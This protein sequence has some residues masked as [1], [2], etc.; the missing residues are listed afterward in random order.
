MFGML[1]PAAFNSPTGLTAC[2]GSTLV[3]TI[4]KYNLCFVYMVK[5]FSVDINTGVM[6]SSVVTYGTDRGFNCTNL[7]VTPLVYNAVV[8]LVG[9]VI[10]V[11]LRVSSLV[12]AYTLSLVCRTFDMCTAGKG[13]MVLSTSCETFN[14]CPN[15]LVLTLVTCLLYTFVLGC[16]GVNACACTVK[17]GRIMTGGVNMGIPGC[18]VMTFALTKFFFKLRTV[19]AVDFNASVA[20]T[21][22]LSSVDHGFA[23]LVKAFFKLTFGGCNRP[24]VTVMVNRVVVRLVFGNFITLKT[25]AAVRGMM[26]NI[27]LLI[28]ITL[29]AG[30]IGNLMMGWKR[31]L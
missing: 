26:A 9:N 13:G 12:I 20:S 6:L 30:P 25:P 16:A 21:S 18:G 10:C 2:V 8:N 7:V 22:G 24:I 5:P 23:P 4:N 1:T 3:C 27:T 11:G 14:S 19:L 29:A 17:D 31:Q 15:G 28:V